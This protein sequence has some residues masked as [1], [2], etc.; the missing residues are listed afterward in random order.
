MTDSAMGSS[1]VRDSPT[2]YTASVPLFTACGPPAD[3]IKLR[4]CTS[5]AIARSGYICLEYGKIST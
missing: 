4:E 2:A 3:S 1:V 5:M